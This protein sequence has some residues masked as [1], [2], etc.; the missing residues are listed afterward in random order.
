MLK[1]QYLFIAVGQVGGANEDVRQQVLNV[2]DSEKMSKL[3]SV[4]TEEVEPNAKVLV[5]VEMKKKADFL[6]ARL[7][8]DKMKCTSIHGD[9]EQRER[10]IALGDFKTG[11]ANVLVA[12]SVAARG[13][14][15]PKV[16]YVINFDMP[17]DIDEYVHRI[18]RT[19][20]VGQQGN[21]ITFID[22]AKDN[23]IL[24]SLVSVL[25][26]ANQVIP[27]WLDQH[28]TGAQ[29]TFSDFSQ[30][31][32]R[33]DIREFVGGLDPRGGGNNNNFSFGGGNNNSAPPADDQF[34][35]LW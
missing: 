6:A 32:G 34:A 26:N 14:D 33:T 25:T 21:A 4:L 24:R 5:F 30:S 11:R 27:P 35:S 13:L 8:Q 3:K 28:A 9:R 18:G 29:G 17:S 22:T 12:T 10:E 15:I 19:G 23:Q 2:P 7:C 31:A 1:Q 20:R 16:A